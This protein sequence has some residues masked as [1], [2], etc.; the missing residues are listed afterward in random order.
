MLRQ[1]DWCLLGGLFLDIRTHLAVI[2]SHAKGQGLQNFL[3]PV[4]LM[5]FFILH[6][7]NYK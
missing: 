1:I 6:K 7:K 4:S 5:F 3:S 2:S